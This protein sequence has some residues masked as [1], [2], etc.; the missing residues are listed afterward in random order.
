MDHEL[1]RAVE[2]CEGPRR[3]VEG[4]EGPRRAVEGREG[5]KLGRKNDEI[6]SL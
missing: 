6:V 4:C 3:A 2:G 5:G 1:W